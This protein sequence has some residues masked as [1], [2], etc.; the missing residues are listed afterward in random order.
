M[1]YIRGEVSNISSHA[2]ATAI[3]I[4]S[5]A[6]SRP[7]QGDGRSALGA[8]PFPELAGV[9]SGAALVVAA[10]VTEAVPLVVV[11]RGLTTSLGL[12]NAV[13]SVAVTGLVT[14]VE[15]RDLVK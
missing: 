11:M 15:L 12:T 14:L 2:T 10:G 3:I 1:H 8:A 5:P 6:A 13:V 7:F 9:E 4:P